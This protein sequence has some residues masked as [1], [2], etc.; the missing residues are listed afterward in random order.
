MS[1]N[2]EGKIVLCRISL[3]ADGGDKI[4]HDY[5]SIEDS[6]GYDKATYLAK[7]NRFKLDKDYQV[8]VAIWFQSVLLPNLG[9]VA[10]EWKEEKYVPFSAIEEPMISP[11]ADIDQLY[12]PC[13]HVRFSKSGICEP[14]KEDK[15][16]LFSAIEKPMFS[17]IPDSDQLYSPFELKIPKSGILEAKRPSELNTQLS[18]LNFLPQ[19]SMMIGLY[20]T[21]CMCTELN[22]LNMD[23]RFMLLALLHGL[24]ARQNAQIMLN[25]IARQGLSLI[26]HR[27]FKKF[28]E[29]VFLRREIITSLHPS[30]ASYALVPMSLLG[31]L[32]RK[33]LLSSLSPEFIIGE[34]IRILPFSI[35]G[36]SKIVNE[37]KEIYRNPNTFFSTSRNQNYIH[38]SFGKRTIRNLGSLSTA[39]LTA[40]IIYVST[41]N[42]LLAVFALISSFVFQADKNVVNESNR[43]GVLSIDNSELKAFRNKYM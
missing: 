14:E 7:M 27:D 2:E 26:I 9:K 25:F 43:T 32:P 16:T 17:P 29:N 38:D 35:V 42:P 22:D 8:K 39:I 36:S 20:E 4:W 3:E 1:I 19:L 30:T 11:I 24:N 23:R 18:E 33:N 40:M 31:C 34:A 13:V 28:C 15:T 12:P 5:F 37:C 41:E 21:Y 10:I 6:I